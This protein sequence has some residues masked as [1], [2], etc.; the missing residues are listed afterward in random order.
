MQSGCHPVSFHMLLRHLLGWGASSTSQ[1]PVSARPAEL[2]ATYA[3]NVKRSVS[4]LLGFR[5]RASQPLGRDTQ[6]V[7]NGCV[8]TQ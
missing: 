1:L 3:A 7:V 6:A 2:S 8:E 5:P 4:G